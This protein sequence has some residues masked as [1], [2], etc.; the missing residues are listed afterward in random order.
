MPS[1]PLPFYEPILGSVFA[2]SCGSEGL[3]SVITRFSKLERWMFV[4]K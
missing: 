3:F 4:V 2:S 1:D